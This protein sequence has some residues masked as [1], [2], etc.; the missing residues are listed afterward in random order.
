MYGRNT[1]S[2]QHY[3][4]GAERQRD[5]LGWPAHQDAQ[6]GA[7][8]RGGTGTVRVGER[9]TEACVTL[10]RVCE[11]VEIFVLKTRFLECCFVLFYSNDGHPRTPAQSPHPSSSNAGS[12][13][14]A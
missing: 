5:F 14:T 12:S 8:R 9:E 4:W 7:P 3:T 10:C 6:A 1:R 11:V 13:K 2:R